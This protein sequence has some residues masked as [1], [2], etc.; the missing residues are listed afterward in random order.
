[1]TSAVGNRSTPTPRPRRKED[2]SKAPGRKAGGSRAETG[3]AISKGRLLMD[4][5]E[6]S[7]N[8][9][10]PRKGRVGDV[11]AHEPKELE[12]SLVKCISRHDLSHFHQTHL[13]VCLRTS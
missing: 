13:T 8:Q 6:Q 9:D 4:K 7:R 3:R 12:G 11:P 10:R 5:V 1:M 2:G